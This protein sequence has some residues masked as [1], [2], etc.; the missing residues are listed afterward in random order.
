MTAT[1]ERLLR[2]IKS[3]PPADVR[4]VWE[5]MGRL[6]EASADTPPQPPVH[7]T[8]EQALR[9]LEALDGRFAGARLLDRLLEERQRDRLR[10]E[11]QL[12]ERR[13]RRDG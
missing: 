7:S 8:T 4:A 6:M 5:H 13:S 3:L 10:E 2:E 12:A 9:A 11:S 1:A